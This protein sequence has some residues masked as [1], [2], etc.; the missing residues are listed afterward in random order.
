MDQTLGAVDCTRDGRDQFRSRFRDVARRRQRMDLAIAQGRDLALRCADEKGCAILHQRLF[1]IGRVGEEYVHFAVS[2]G[3]HLL[4]A[5]YDDELARPIRIHRRPGIERAQPRRHFPRRV[6]SLRPLAPRA[7]RATT[8]ASKSAVSP[9]RPFRTTRFIGSFASRLAKRRMRFASAI[10]PRNIGGGSSATSA[11]PLNSIWPVARGEGGHE[12]M[13]LQP[14]RL[15]CSAAY[16]NPEREELEI[17]LGRRLDAHWHQCTRTRPGLRK[18]QP[19][20]RTGGE[21]HDRI[22]LRA[23]RNHPPQI[24]LP[25]IHRVV[26]SVAI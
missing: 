23:H 25:C 4:W 20:Q 9:P 11:S 8:R 18:C 19:A 3:L 26:I 17:G 2:K 12:N 24:S 16:R 5:G 15:E 1:Q 21:Q 13:R 22:H 14:F 6:R 10:I 7:D